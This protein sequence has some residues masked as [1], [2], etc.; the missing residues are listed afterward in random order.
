[1][2]AVL[3]TGVLAK[4]ETH[5]K[6]FDKYCE[7]G[8]CTLTLYGGTRNVYED[9]Q[10][11][12]IED[13]R[14]LKDH[15]DIN[16]LSWDPNFPVGVIDFNYTQI[17]FNLNFTGDKEKYVD[18]CY[19]DAR[20]NEKCNFKLKTKEMVFDP[21]KQEFEEQETEIEIE[22]EMDEGQTKFKYEYT[23]DGNPF[24][25]EF[26]YGTNS[27][28]LNLVDPNTE[29]LENTYINQYFP[30]TNYGTDTNMGVTTANAGD[31]EQVSLLKWNVSSIPAGSNILTADMNL[32]A[33]VNQL[34]AGESMN[35]S[36]KEI[37]GV[38]PWT[39]DD[40]TW[41]T[42]PIDS[43][44]SSTIS[45]TFSCNNS[46]PPDGG[47]ITFNITLALQSVVNDGEPNLSLYLYGHDNVSVEDDYVGFYT[48]EDGGGRYPYFNITYNE[49]TTNPLWHNQFVNESSPV[50]DEYMSFNITITDESSLG[51]YV[52]SWTDS[53][54]WV[55]DS[56]VALSGTYQNVTVVKQISAIGGTNISWR[57]HFDDDSSN[58]NSSTISTFIVGNTAPPQPT[59]IQPENKSITG[60]A[61]PFFNWTPVTDIDEDSVTYEFMLA[62]LSNMS[63]VKFNYTG[64]TKSDNITATLA[65]NVYYWR[66]R[67][68]DNDSVAGAWSDVWQ[69]EVNTSYASINDQ[70][71]NPAT[72]YNNN[73]VWLNATITDAN[74]ISNVW[75][76]G[77]WSGDWVNYT[78]VTNISSNYCYELGSGNLSNLQNVSWRFIVNNS[79]G[80]FTTAAIN[81][82]TVSNRAPW[83][84]SNHTE[85]VGVYQGNITYVYVNV[86]D[87]DGDTVTSVNFSI[88]PPNGTYIYSN[89]TNTNGF[90][91]SSFFTPDDGGD[92][93][94]NATIADSHTTT[95]ISGS[96]FI[97]DSTF[98]LI[99]MHSPISGDSFSGL[100]IELQFFPYDE[101]RLSNCFYSDQLAFVGN[102]SIDCT[103]N[104]TSFNAITYGAH[105]FKFYVNDTSGNINYTSFTYT[106]E[107]VSSTGSPGG[108]GTPA[109]Q[110]TT[111][112]NVTGQCGNGVCDENEDA[113]NCPSD[114]RGGDFSFSLKEA[115]DNIKSFF[116]G[117]IVQGWFVSLSM[118][119]LIIIFIYFGY[120][121]LTG[122]SISIFKRKSNKQAKFEGLLAYNDG[123]RAAKKRQAQQANEYAKRYYYGG[124]RNKRR[125]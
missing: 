122:N 80:K 66:V 96:I 28:V 77:N 67:A 102:T 35:I 83:K 44:V 12:R 113:F 8:V 7:D 100:T 121:S 56:E 30:T 82:F 89:G 59:L 79:I 115:I 36:V 15:F 110:V 99:T 95:L 2:A 114:C 97:N 47:W 109:T 108:G 111:F 17:K 112:V 34:D 13:A 73:T 60:D 74:G 22:Y 103:N 18:Y 43:N 90:W 11:K 29:N 45:D 76:S 21:V 118:L 68:L 85:P 10:W 62:N 116:K 92:W 38:F 25:I 32:Y 72:I 70:V 3:A 23:Y 20:N 98:P 87:A 1:M 117:E 27:T 48:K 93:I 55:N 125:R 49:D 61:T 31:G 106:N 123:R 41:D 26:K 124:M 88:R 46:Y 4:S 24:G 50:K 107:L 42:R 57:F 33:W 120:S 39:E 6:D 40:I 19:I 65:D 63:L 101:T 5:G 119:S 81:S 51:G 78:V 58:P 75:V 91:N 71:D 86:S 84:I 54:D 105:Q 53:G 37:E 69:L 14:S 64:L 52:F 16:Y 104:D 9:D 94:W